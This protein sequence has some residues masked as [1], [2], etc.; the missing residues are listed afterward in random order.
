MGKARWS[1]RHS[2]GGDVDDLATPLPPHRRSDGARTQPRAP[3]IYGEA[4]V[5][6]LIGKLSEVLLEDGAVIGSIVDEAI[7]FGRMPSPLLPPWLR[8]RP[9]R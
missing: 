1:S 7:D 9:G 3:H 8:L 4:M 5:P 2:H 6:F